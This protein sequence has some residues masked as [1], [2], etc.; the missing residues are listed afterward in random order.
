MLGTAAYTI[1]KDQEMEKNIEEAAAYGAR[2]AE[3]GE[4]ARD[5]SSKEEELKRQL[6]RMSMNTSRPSKKL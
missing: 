2:V 4:P 1:D 6:V 5:L 3:L